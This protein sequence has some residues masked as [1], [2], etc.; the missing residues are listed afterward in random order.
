MKMHAKKKGRTVHVDVTLERLPKVLSLIFAKIP[1]GQTPEQ[2][3]RYV[4]LSSRYL[5]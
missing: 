1:Q 5:D 3:K 2:D 4:S